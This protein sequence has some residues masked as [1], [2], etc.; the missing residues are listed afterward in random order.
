MGLVVIALLV[1]LYAAYMARNIRFSLRSLLI[2]MTFV[3]VVLGL[4]LLVL[5][6]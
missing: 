4:V 1:V 3:A 5:R 2:V 6:K